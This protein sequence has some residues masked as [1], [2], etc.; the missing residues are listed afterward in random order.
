MTRQHIGL[1]AL[2]VR[3][4]DEARAW[5]CGVLGFNLI[6]DTPLPSATEGE[7]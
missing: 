4:Y 5:Y 6:E 1:V 2:V 3:D 7:T